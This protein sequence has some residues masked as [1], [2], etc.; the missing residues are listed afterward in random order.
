MP[1]HFYFIENNITLVQRK[2]LKLFIQSIAEKEKRPI[3]S[4]NY[5]F[6]SDQ[7][8]LEMNI[9]YLKHNFFT[10]VITFDLSETADRIVGEVY[11]SIDRVKAKAAE[12][13]VLTNEELHRV[14]FHGVLHLCGYKDKS[15]PDIDKMRAAENKYLKLYFN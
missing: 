14:I 8:L 6:C 12:L 11:I 2:K 5:I 3:E 7:Y 15:K 1:V 4:L 9:K 10:D 13:S